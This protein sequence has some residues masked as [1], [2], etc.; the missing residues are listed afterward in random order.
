MGQFGEQVH[1]M[2]MGQFGYGHPDPSNH[3]LGPQRRGQGFFDYN[4]AQYYHQNQNDDDDI[5]DIQ[6]AGHSTWY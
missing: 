5:E 3:G 2:P 4:I 1:L 6:P